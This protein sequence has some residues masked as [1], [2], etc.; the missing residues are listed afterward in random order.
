MSS[1]ARIPLMS[2]VMET[3]RPGAP[4]PITHLNHAKLDSCV[5]QG[6]TTVQ[7][8]SQACSKY[9]TFLPFSNTL[10][11]RTHSCICQA[12]F[13]AASSLHECQKFMFPAPNSPSVP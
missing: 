4:P 6:C 8:F 10:S 5:A 1:C 2:V 3:L 12:C 7:N 13:S 9:N 11:Q